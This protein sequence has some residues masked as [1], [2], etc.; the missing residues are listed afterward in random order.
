M[1]DFYLHEGNRYIVKN[2][3]KLKIC[4]AILFVVLG[5]YAYFKHESSLRGI[6]VA[7]VLFAIAG[8][9][10]AA[11]RVKMV[12]DLDKRIFYIQAGSGKQTFNQSLDNFAGLELIRQ[13]RFFGLM[14][15]SILNVVF[16]VDGKTVKMPIRQFGPGQQAP[17]AMIEETETFLGISHQRNA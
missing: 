9:M 6:I 10:L 12:F 7:L 4:L 1:S 14:R 17:Q 5:I 13:F 16:D 3:K 15:N 11:L 8:V 2:Q